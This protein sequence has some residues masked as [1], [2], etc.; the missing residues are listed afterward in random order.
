MKLAICGVCGHMGKYIASILPKEDQIV[1]GF[2]QRE[3]TLCPVEGEI[4]TFF[5]Y[6]F[7]MVIDFSCAEVAFPIIIEALRRG[8]KVIT[9]TTGFSSNQLDEMFF[10]AEY[11]Q[12]SLIWCMNFTMGANVLLQLVQRAKP[13]FQD[14]YLI[15]THRLGKK[16][17]PSGTALEIAKE[18]K[19]AENHVQSLRIG[20]VLGKHK[21]ILYHEGEILTIE[22]SITDQKAYQ[23]GFL[24]YLELLKKE[25]MILFRGLHYL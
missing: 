23:N 24:Y 18:A 13:Y 11:N 3:T 5:S 8:K 9:G 19:I 20:E 14:C 15:E 10:C 4:Q 2:D 16:D 21:I 7:E 25:K 22:H 17:A 1:V 6:D 12:T